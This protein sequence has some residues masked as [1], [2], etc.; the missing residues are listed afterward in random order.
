MAL[1]LQNQ[2]WPFFSKSG[3]ADTPKGAIKVIFGELYANGRSIMLVMPQTFNIDVSWGPE[4]KD[5][6]H[7]IVG[8]HKEGLYYPTISKEAKKMSSLSL[9]I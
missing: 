7:G 6:Q 2:F 4:S 1:P 3:S 8:Y 9:Q 5:S